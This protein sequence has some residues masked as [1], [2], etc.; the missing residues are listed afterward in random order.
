[1]R[2]LV[3]ERVHV[4]AH[5][6]DLLGLQQPAA[7]HSRM[8][9]GLLFLAWGWDLPVVCLHPSSY[10]SSCGFFIALVIGLL[11]SWSSGGS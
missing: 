10:Q 6:E 11:F 8:L 1:M 5:Q 9:W 2:E 3:S 7:S 4:Q